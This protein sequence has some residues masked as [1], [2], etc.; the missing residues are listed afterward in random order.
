MYRVV[1]YDEAQHAI[2]ALPADAVGGFAE[3]HALL[4]VDP[5]SGTPYIPGKSDGVMRTLPFGLSG[6]ALFLILDDQRRVDVIQ[7][8]WHG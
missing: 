6:M 7:V 4:E 5:W 3:L 8:Y 1:I 2:D